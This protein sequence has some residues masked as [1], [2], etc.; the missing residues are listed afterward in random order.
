MPCRRSCWLIWTAQQVGD[1]PDQVGVVLGLPLGLH[2]G[3][4]L[5]P[6]VELG[7]PGKL[8]HPADGGPQSDDAT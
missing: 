7:I 8:P 4:S 1:P 3:R 6:G 2:Y 5:L